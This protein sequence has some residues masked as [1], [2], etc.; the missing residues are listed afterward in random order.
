MDIADITRRMRGQA[1]SIE[2][3]TRA[4]NDE[5]VRWRWEPG[6]WSV[7]E[8]LCHMVDE[9]KDDFRTRVDLA[10]HHPE[11][12]WPGIDPEAWARD[13][14]YNERVPAETLGAFLEER[15]RSIAWLRGL[16]DPD[17]SSTHVHPRLG[18]MS[19]GDVM[20][21]WV[22]HDLLHMRQ[23]AGILYRL[24]ERDGAPFTGAY[25]GP[26]NG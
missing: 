14:A 15:A 9:E 1:A 13:R 7:L 5:E 20:T 24:T 3:L 19:A 18:S 4:L 6:R 23:I 21:S 8:V 25:A 10:L 16:E 12:A 2:H 17:W 26:W 22:V 11:R